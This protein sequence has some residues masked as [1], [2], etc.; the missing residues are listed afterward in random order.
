MVSLSR[1]DGGPGVND[2]APVRRSKALSPAVLNCAVE[3]MRG[4]RILE[5]AGHLRSIRTPPRPPAVNIRIALFNLHQLLPQGMLPS[6]AATPQSFHSA[7][8]PWRPCAMRQPQERPPQPFYTVWRHTPQRTGVLPPAYTASAS[9]CNGG[10]QGSE[11]ERVRGSL[12]GDNGLE[13][14]WKKHSLARQSSTW[15][16]T[17]RS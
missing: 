16:R 17:L 13:M 8:L 3:S 5:A 7:E 15:G 9:A 6:P 1:C 4:R 14:E 2:S 12:I 10:D 11:R